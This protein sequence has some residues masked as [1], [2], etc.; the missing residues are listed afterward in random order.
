[1]LGTGEVPGI[2]AAIAPHAPLAPG[3]VPLTLY[4]GDSPRSPR[5]R[6]HQP[7]GSHG[8][9]RRISTAPALRADSRRRGTTRT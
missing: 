6:G 3:T 9:S 4:K 2:L 7:L 8:A 1:V 5:S